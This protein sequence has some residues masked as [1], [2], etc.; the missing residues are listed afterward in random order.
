MK[1]LLALL[2]LLA[3]PAQAGE[4]P[5][6]EWGNCVVQAL[7]PEETQRGSVATWA[8]AAASRCHPL[9][10]G[11]PDFEVPMAVRLLERIREMAVGSSPTPMAPADRRF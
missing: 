8:I 10:R 1:R 5:P 9:Y 3:V 6:P 11:D 2:L 7:L 4:V